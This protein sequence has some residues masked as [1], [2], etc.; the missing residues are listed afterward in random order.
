MRRIGITYRPDDE[1]ECGWNRTALT[2]AELFS[3][4]YDVVLVTNQV[5]GWWDC[6]EKRFETAELHQTTGLDL[7]IDID[8]LVTPAARQRASTCVIFLRTFLQFTEMDASVYLETPFVPRSYDGV[9][10]IWCWDILNPA[11][12]LAS[13]Q[14]LFPCPLRTVPFVW[15]PLLAS[16]PLANASNASK[17]WAVHIAE[18]NRENTSSSVLPLVAIRELSK[19][20][21]AHFYVHNM[22]VIKDNK[23]LKE[24]V[25]DNIDA[26]SLPLT[27]VPKEPFKAWG[28]HSILLSHSRFVPLRLA[29]L[30][31]LWMGI[32][33]IHNSPVLKGLHPSLE[34]M[35]Y[36]GNE[37]SGICAAFSAFIKE[38]HTYYSA[39]PAIR[40]A[41]L[42]AFS[43]K[44]WTAV[45]A[46]IFTKG[47]GA[48]EAASEAAKETKELRI[49]F[50]DMWPGFNFDSN[51]ILDALRKNGT[52]CKGFEYSH[53]RGHD[54]LNCGPYP[55]GHDISNCGPYPRGHDILICGPYS[56]RWRDIAGPKIFFSAENWDLPTDPSIQLYLTSRMTE[57]SRHLRIPTW[58]TFIDWFSGS[59]EVPTNHKDNP[60]RF[61]VHFAMTPHAIPFSK[62]TN[63]CAFVVSN[64][65]CTF[66]NRAFEALHAYQHVTSG[67]ALYNNIGGQ[68]DLKYAGGGCGDVSKYHCFEKHRF[69]LSF[70]NSQAPGYV[71]EKLLHAKMAGCVPLYWGDA[72][73]AEF[74]P[75]SFVNLSRA[76][77]TDSIVQAVKVL[78][79]S[80]AVCDI[81]AATPLLD[82]VRVGLAHLRMK[83]MCEAILRASRA[84]R[85]LGP[86]GPLP[87]LGPSGPLPALPKEPA[88][89]LA[90]IDNTYIINLDT[91]RDR[92]DK[93]MAAEPYLQSA[94]RVAGVNGKTLTMNSEIYHMFERNEFQWK[95]SII[96]CNLS[97][98]SV[99]KRV[100]ESGT[101][102]L[103]LE[104][105]VRFHN[106]WLS[107]WPA[108]QQA[109]PADADV[110][111]LGGVLPPNK[112]ALPSASRAVN[113]YWSQ[114]IPNTYF[115]PSPIAVFHF[116]AYSYILTQRGAQKL[117][118]FMMD[119]EK[120]SFT[121]S[122][123]LLGH[124]AVG[125]VKYHANPLLSFCFQ[126]S[127]PVYVSSQF[128][129]LHREDK[130]DSDIWN[131]KECFEESELAPFRQP[132][133]PTG[134]K[135][136]SKET[137]SEP[138]ET[139]KETPSE[140]SAL[141]M[142]YMA[143][144]RKPFEPYERTW[145]HDIF[146]RPIR[147]VLLENV[148]LGH[149]AWF[150]VQRPYLTQYLDLFQRLEEARIPFHVLHLSDE[151]GHDP[152][153]FYSLSMCQSV[154]RNYPRSN[155]VFGPHVHTIPL[156][157]HHK[158]TDNKKTMSQ[159]ELRWSFH[160]TDWFDRA[161][162]LAEFTSFVPYR[163]NL[164]PHWNHP[165]KTRESVYLSQL[166][167]S[168]FCP[169][170]KGQHAETF[171]FYEALEAGT[172][173]VTNITDEVWLDWIEKEMGLSSL[174]PWK[175]V[176]GV[177]A[178]GVS[179]EIRVE[180]VRR[181][182]AWKA[183]VLQII[184][185][186][187]I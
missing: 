122:D 177:M 60:I 94:T 33:V 186:C 171:R 181:W 170:L 142:Y 175:D 168:Q 53:D 124:P 72:D 156:G 21:D 97:H 23:F 157:Y 129:D 118:A 64:P 91:R 116:C 18:K 148:Q 68:L 89:T 133:G 138:S 95:K 178:S 35:F 154:I 112:P 99:W 104:D 77:D 153:F 65:S 98:I 17:P 61:P 130:F 39:V 121:V 152:L 150:V 46:R 136:T 155:I 67:G 43:K 123:H 2:L 84:E 1:L 103:V 45:L 16:K 164:Q 20:T 101:M 111:Y 49:A 139:S 114:I 44:D 70:E 119:S 66:R 96:G 159:R 75:N 24:N 83:R 173:P 9:T 184:Q 4:T 48:L 172:L 34:R 5:A 179:E 79:A 93:L 161:K 8:G 166:G 59:T 100:A 80:E 141:T 13:I 63:F 126:E 22:D 32:P 6:L 7:L 185:T 57:D 105:D 158:Y 113:S 180:V 11:A 31:A 78:E 85:V 36:R 38:P 88:F 147:F 71:T 76:V 144:D 28:D 87:A 117:M 149:H 128:N 73:V 108:Y 165:T 106:G 187:K 162:Q 127:D 29:L 151:F 131:N 86:S 50:S 55:R 74:V 110:L 58:M 176:R 62:R 146:Q 107:M 19:I 169:I 81:M 3:S 47:E 54:I 167:N 132:L 25:L 143:H 120:R 27:M 92:W 134:S 183:R 41:M 102:A 182:A 115:S 90:G 137:P 10:E 140:P 30:D 51:F 135:G 15:T 56:E 82:G 160:G 69:T 163:C 26:P 52:V 37:I 14:T 174:Y 40:E 109:I 12:S 125:L 42:A 145:L